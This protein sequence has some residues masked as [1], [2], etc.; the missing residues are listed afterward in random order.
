MILCPIPNQ[1]VKEN[2]KKTNKLEIINKY[3]GI[4]DNSI[5][6]RSL[7]DRQPSPPYSAWFI[8][9]A[10]AV[11]GRDQRFKVLFLGFGEC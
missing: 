8:K 7:H 11:K 1:T 4:K 5:T 9:S 3:G 2:W 6:K 10:V